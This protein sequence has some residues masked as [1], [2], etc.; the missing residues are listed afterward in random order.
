MKICFW[1]NGE[2]QVSGRDHGHGLQIALDVVRQLRHH[3]ARDGERADRTD[4]DGVAVGRGFRHRVDADGERTPGAVIDDDALPKLLGN[5][6]RDEPR[7]V[8]GRA[9][10][11]LRDDETQRPLRVLSGRRDCEKE[12]R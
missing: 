6:R 3:V 1:R 2:Q 10:R 5:A 12:K 11:G 7:D 4:A 9:A 8:V